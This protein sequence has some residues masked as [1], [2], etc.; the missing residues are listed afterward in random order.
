MDAMLASHSLTREAEKDRPLLDDIRLLGRLLG[1]TI[2]E[3]EGDEAFER[4]EKVRRLSV[5][6]ETGA[7]SEAGAA[8]DALLRALTPNEAVSVA[9]AFSHFSFLTNIAE[10]RHHV[11]RRS[12]TQ[13][14][15]A[16]QPGSLALTF[17]LLGE[18][19]IDPGTAGKMLGQSLVCPVL[20]AHPT[21]VQ[22]RSA[23]DAANAIMS[24]LAARE[25]PCG[26]REAYENDL[27]LR[28]KI[29]QICQ[30]R[31]LRFTHLTVH[32]EIE[33]ALTFY[34][35]SFFSEI[36]QL[37]A[38]LE[39][40]LEGASPGPFFQMGSW[41]GGDRDGNPNVNAETLGFA[42]K[43]QCE[44]ALLHYLDEIHE[45]GAEL[46]VSRTL[47]GCSAEL[48][49]LA[50]RSGDN[51]PHREDEPYRRALIGIYARLAATL[52]KLTGTLAP[53]PALS[54]AEPYRDAEELLADLTIVETSLAE[55]RG[56]LLTRARLHPLRR[57]VEVF[58]FH[59]AA[60]DLRQSSDRHEDTLA[61]L[62]AVA[63]VAAD[64]RSSGRNTE[65]SA[66]P[67]HP[68]RS[69]PSACAWS[70]LLGQDHGR[71]GCPRCRARFAPDLR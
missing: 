20:T 13:A 42:L 17:K 14:Y 67:V 66:A 30:T 36:P 27:M 37:Y 12:A 41:I 21:E 35:T 46:S 61:E 56:G 25:G 58:G 68:G 2:R 65:A 57:A 16:P 3:Q 44:T 48:E 38:A 31:L 8:L 5:A 63:R 1:E 47:V 52:L 62:F 11:R 43:R 33:N 26:E 51:N 60:L 7:D 23:L 15:L 55:H 45:L 29:A 32:D 6:F 71:V 18:A 22:R 69:A 9:R 64:Y 50:E 4:V 70:R 19:G 10:D 40:R 39:Q 59:L 49:A 54:S 28:A 34:R 24:L 53:R